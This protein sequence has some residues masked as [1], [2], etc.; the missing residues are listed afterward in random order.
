M[1]RTDVAGTT[2]LA[3]ATLVLALG[4]SAAAGCEMGTTGT[5]RTWLG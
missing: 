4:G 2:V 1:L 3:G 5:G